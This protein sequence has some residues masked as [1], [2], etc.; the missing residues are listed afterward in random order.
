M[1]R[2]VF[3]LSLPHILV[4][5]EFDHFLSIKGARLK[6]KEIIDLVETKLLAEQIS[7]KIGRH[8]VLC[9]GKITLVEIWT[10]SSYPSL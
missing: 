8:K 2:E 4:F 5:R 10:K 6:E 3:I 7:W 1:P 9:R